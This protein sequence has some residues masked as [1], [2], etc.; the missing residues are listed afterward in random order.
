M[1]DDRVKLRLFLGRD[2]FH[3]Q[4]RERNLV[5]REVLQQQQHQGEQDDRRGA[6][7]GG[8][9]RGNEGHVDKPEQEHRQDHARLEAAVLSELHAACH[10]A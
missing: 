1:V 10:Y 4:R 6:G 8:D 2:L 7:P 9:Q 3:A 5:R